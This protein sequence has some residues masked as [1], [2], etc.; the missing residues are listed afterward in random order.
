GIRDFHVTGVQ[1][2]ALPISWSH[3]RSAT[4]RA[5]PRARAASA[6]TAGGSVTTPP[7]PA[8]RPRARRRVRGRAGTGENERS[9]PWVV[10]SAPVTGALRREGGS[11]RG[12]L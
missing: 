6:S 4:G 2:C 11:V 1:T 9:R 8:R 3:D 10:R 5:G 12:T 7:S